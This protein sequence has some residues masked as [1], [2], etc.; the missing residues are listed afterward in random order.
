MVT[1]D[2]PRTAKAI[3]DLEGLTESGKVLTGS[4]LDGMS[5]EELMEVAE[6]VDIYART[7]PDHKSRLVDA[8]QSN[9]EI[10]AMTGDGIN[11]APAVKSADVGVGMG[12][13]G[14]DV[15]KEASDVILQDDDF[16]TLVTAV[17]NGRRIYD[18]I[19]KFT[20]YLVSRNF[21]EVIV[22]I[23]GIMMFLD[24]KQLPLIAIQILFLNLIGEEM[25]A[26]ALG[27]DPPLG[28][29]HGKSTKEDGS[30]D[31][32]QAKYVLHTTYGPLHGSNF[33]SRLQP[34][35]PPR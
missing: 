26:V 2:D 29:Y 11:D 16:A 6:E 4:E 28:A 15:T 21:T 23:L 9:E 17:E 27:L 34:F 7:M 10:V 35:P 1:G 33:L 8:Y 30:E 20:T 25:P 24:F 31:T 18:N 3:T 13:E 32:S 19:E 12:M 22:I 5:D 14:T